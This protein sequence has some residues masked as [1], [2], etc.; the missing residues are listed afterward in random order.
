M[1]SN[2]LPTPC[3][4]EQADNFVLLSGKRSTLRFAVLHHDTLHKIQRK[5]PT[6]KIV[7]L[8]QKIS[9]AGQV[10]SQV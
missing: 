10:P 4:V 2:S 3:Q 7:L 9:F 6:H 1:Q 8:G 5:I